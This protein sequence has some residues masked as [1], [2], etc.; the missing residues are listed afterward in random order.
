MADQ[1][2]KSAQ[3]DRVGLERLYAERNAYKCAL[4][5][6]TEVDEID[7][8]LDPAWPEYSTKRFWLPGSVLPY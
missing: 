2:R 8:A 6:I 5:D 3:A 7:A 1:S 4:E